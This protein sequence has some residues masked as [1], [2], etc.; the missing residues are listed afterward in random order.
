[1][2][3]SPTAGPSFREPG[4]P[5]FL[6]KNKSYIRIIMRVLHRRPYSLY[7]LQSSPRFFYLYLICSSV[8]LQSSPQNFKTLYLFNRNS[9]FIDFYAK[10]FVATKPI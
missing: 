7:K 9:V 8:Y 2:D 1:M 10:S 6:M 4:S 5:V 3:R